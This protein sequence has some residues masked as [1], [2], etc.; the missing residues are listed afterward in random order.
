MSKQYKKTEEKKKEY[1]KGC[2]AIDFRFHQQEKLG[3]SEQNEIQS[4]IPFRYSR[5]I[6]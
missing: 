4:F 5:Y 6:E 1:K 2:K 3:T